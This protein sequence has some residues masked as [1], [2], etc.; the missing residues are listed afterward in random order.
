MHDEAQ[1]GQVVAA[2]HLV[3]QPQQAHEHRRHHVHVGDAM[4]LDQLQQVLGIEARFEH[5]GAAAAERQHAVGV[6]RRMIHRAVHQD[7]LVLVRLDAIGDAADALRGGDLLGRIGLRRTP[8][9][10]PV[11]PDV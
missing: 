2:L 4:T 10:R 1:R 3:R 7:D 9:G 6:R 5:D 11:V 8:F